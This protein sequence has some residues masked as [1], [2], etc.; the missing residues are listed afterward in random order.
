MVV[1]VA[2]VVVIATA[3][4]GASSTPTGSAGV[5][6][7]QATASSP[8]STAN[9][10]LC[11]GFQS[12]LDTVWKESVREQVWKKARENMELFD[13]P[14]PDVNAA[15]QKYADFI[16]PKLPAVKKMAKNLLKCAQQPEWNSK[17]KQLCARAA[18]EPVET[19]QL[20]SAL[21]LPETKG[22]PEPDPSF[23]CLV[24]RTVGILGDLAEANGD[25]MALSTG[26]DTSNLRLDVILV[27]P[28]NVAGNLVTTLE[29]WG[30][31]SEDMNPT[32]VGCDWS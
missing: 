6:T 30:T 25:L 29:Q 2:P 8:A 13:C 24:E 21:T 5:P 22:L 32:S 11:A 18:L 26:N 16:V 14:M 20:V 23:D 27:K 15:R 3:C 12:D 28:A 1:G 31:N 17:A 7:A 9:A 10:E 4:G 19:T